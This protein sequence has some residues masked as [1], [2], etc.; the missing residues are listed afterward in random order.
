[1]LTVNLYLTHIHEWQCFVNHRNAHPSASLLSTWLKTI[2]AYGFRTCSGSIKNRKPSKHTKSSVEKSSKMSNLLSSW[3][4][5]WIPD[6]PLPP[7]YE[8]C[9]YER[10]RHI[11]FCCCFS[12]GMTS[13]S[14]TQA[15]LELSVI[16]LLHL[17]S[18]EITDRSH[19]A[20]LLCICV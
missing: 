9:S 16:L 11:G 10:D 18:A 20:R 3:E 12:A 7:E 6:L 1:M 4:W 2:Q 17:P 15:S 19:H 8:D 5:P 14:I 13:H